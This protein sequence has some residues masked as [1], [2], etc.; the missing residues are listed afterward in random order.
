MSTDG[1][2]HRNVTYEATHIT[3]KAS[4]DY[5]DP[6][7]PLAHRTRLVH[8]EHVVDGTADTQLENFKQ[9][10]TVVSKV[11]T[12]S[13]LASRQNLK[14]ERNDAARKNMGLNG[15]HCSTNLKL[16]DGMKGWKK[17]V[18]TEDLGVERMLELT[19]GDLDTLLAK[20]LDEVDIG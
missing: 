20:A 17:D 6:S 1:T 18:R 16:G 19:P 10:A 7:A 9:T 2:S 12:E 3:L 4:T 15:D 8:V 13:P 11:F 5:S 14:L